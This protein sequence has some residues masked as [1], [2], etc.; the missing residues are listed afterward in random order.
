[1]EWMQVCLVN[2]FMRWDQSLEGPSP[3]HPPAYRVE[4]SSLCGH[5][6]GHN[7]Q[8][9]SPTKHRHQHHHHHHQQK[10]TT[11]ALQDCTAFMHG[12]TTQSR[13]LSAAGTHLSTSPRN[14][15]DHWQERR[16]R[17]NNNNNNNI[18]FLQTIHPSRPASRGP[19]A[20]L[21]NSPRSSLR[22]FNLRP[23]LCN[24][25]SLGLQH[26][27]SSS[28]AGSI[29]RCNGSLPEGGKTKAGRGH[30][31]LELWSFVPPALLLLMLRAR[32]VAPCVCSVW[33]V[34]T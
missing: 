17:K 2:G 32:P 20:V 9:V 5:D 23:S 26:R 24:E 22:P 15:Q 1:M 34:H 13:W 18:P 33:Q 21:P 6:L 11:F 8:Q 4:I 19:R 10:S 3:A 7:Q 25:S 29:L 14:H 31:I 16:K 28:A 27:T 12:G 30:D